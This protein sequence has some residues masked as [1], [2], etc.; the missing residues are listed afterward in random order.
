MASLLNSIK[1][2]NGKLAI[3]FAAS[4]GNLDI[5]KALVKYGADFTLKDGM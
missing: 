2:G 5:F 4:R 3:H 1:E